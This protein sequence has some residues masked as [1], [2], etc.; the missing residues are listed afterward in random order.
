MV[1]K[2]VNYY[3]NDG[4]SIFDE[5][6]TLIDYKVSYNIEL[7]RREYSLIFESKTMEKDNQLDFIDSY[8]RW[9]EQMVWPSVEGNVQWATIAL[10]SEVGEFSQMV[11]KGIR[12]GNTYSKEQISSELGDIM[13]YVSYLCTLHDIKLSDLMVDNINKLERRENE[14]TKQD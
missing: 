12:K 11:E 13:W 4:E 5:D 2:T 14:R 6:L 9:V 10:T 1:L 3:V 7:R 8:Q